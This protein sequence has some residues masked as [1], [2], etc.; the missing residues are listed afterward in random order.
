MSK[1]P[2]SNLSIPKEFKKKML[3]CECS[4]TVSIVAFS[5]YDPFDLPNK[6]QCLQVLQGFLPYRSQSEDEGSGLRLQGVRSRIQ[7]LGSRFVSLRFSGFCK[8]P[9]WLPNAGH[10]SRVVLQDH[11]LTLKGFKV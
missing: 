3:P 1:H 11:S 10:A 2:K 6:P 7:A 9:S 8:D 4:I 5:G